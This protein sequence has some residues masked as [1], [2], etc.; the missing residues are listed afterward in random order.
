MNV[1]EA[2]DAIETLLSEPGDLLAPDTG[3]GGLWEEGDETFPFWSEAGLY[4]RVGKEAAV[5]RARASGKLVRCETC[6]AERWHDQKCL[7]CLAR[8]G[9]AS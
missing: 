7:R 1:T 4:G 6:G 2:L 3:P 9:G 5:F 8:E